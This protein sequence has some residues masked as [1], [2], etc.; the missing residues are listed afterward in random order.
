M[1][2][3]TEPN[4]HCRRKSLQKRESPRMSLWLLGGLRTLFTCSL[5]SRFHEIVDHFIH[6]CKVWSESIW[7][8]LQEF[9]SS[10][11]TFQTTDEVSICPFIRW[12]YSYTRKRTTWFIWHQTWNFFSL[13]NSCVL[14]YRITFDLWPQRVIVPRMCGWTFPR[15]LHGI[16]HT[17]L[18]Y[19]SMM[20][21][22]TVSCSR[23]S[24]VWFMIV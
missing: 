19:V 18:L 16:T 21:R 4:I 5:Y 17:R 1:H 2:T 14:S 20:T 10:Y 11:F 3:R 7:N 6:F 9:Y 12:R 8:T 22:T 23:P 13:I 15:F 24:V